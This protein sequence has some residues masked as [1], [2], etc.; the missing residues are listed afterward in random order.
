MTAPNK[1]LE[2][3]PFRAKRPGKTIRRRLAA[4]KV[5]TI[6][7]QPEARLR[8]PAPE[9]LRLV[10]KRSSLEVP[11]GH[12]LQPEGDLQF[13]A[14]MDRKEANVVRFA[15]Q[16]Q[17]VPLRDRLRVSLDTDQG[18]PT[19]SDRPL[20]PPTQQPSVQRDA[21]LAASDGPVPSLVGTAHELV[22]VHLDDRQATRQAPNIDGTVAK[23]FD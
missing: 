19:G 7:R 3:L 4:T 6:S 22:I 9:G 10:S 14:D 17:S 8:G 13:A 11:I 2:R 1:D 12:V 21:A 23:L 18:E 20:S 16:D 15:H 5:A